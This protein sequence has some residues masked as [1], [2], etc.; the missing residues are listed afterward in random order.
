MPIEK[1]QGSDEVRR[2]GVDDRVPTEVTEDVIR[3]RA[4]ELYKAR[5][6]EPERTLT[7]GFI[8]NENFMS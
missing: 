5:G 2:P 6:G 3:G 8:R 4:Y 7:I 1:R